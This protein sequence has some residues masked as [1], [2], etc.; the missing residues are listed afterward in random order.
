MSTRRRAALPPAPPPPQYIPPTLQTERPHPEV[1]RRVR[2]S[3]AT[4]QLSGKA[5]D[6]KPLPFAFGTVETHGSIRYAFRNGKDL[7][8]VRALALGK[9]SATAGGA[10]S[11]G[12]IDSL[13]SVKSETGFSPSM[14][15]FYESWFYTGSLVQTVN[16]QLAAI[17]ASWNETLIVTNPLTG[18]QRGI[19]YIVERYLN[20]V[21]YWQRYHGGLPKWLYRL[22]GSKLYDS[23]TGLTAYTENLFLQWRY[24]ATDPDGRNLPLASIDTTSFNAAATIGDQV[25]GTGKRYEAHVLMESGTV[26]DWLKMF[27]LLGDA[28]WYEK[29][30]GRWAVLIDS[31][32]APVATFTD[33]HYT[34]SRQVELGPPSD[35]DAVVNK[36]TIEYT[37]TT[38]AAWRTEPVTL[39]MPGVAAGTEPE[40]AA[41]YKMPELHH[42]AQA[43]TKLR[44]LLYGAQDDQRLSLNWRPN[45]GERVLG[46]VITQ[47]IPER[48]ISGDFRIF[49]RE[50]LPDGTIN[51]E[52]QQVSPRKYSDSTSATP[53]KF[54]S[55]PPPLSIPAPPMPAAHTLVDAW[56]PDGSDTT[57]RW[58]PPANYNESYISHYEVLKGRSDTGWKLWATVQRDARPTATNPLIVTGLTDKNWD[59]LTLG[60]TRSISFDIVAVTIDGQRS[61]TS[62][63]LGYSAGVHVAQSVS[64][65]GAA[66]RAA[67]Y[68]TQM[69]TLLSVVNGGNNNLAWQS[70][71]PAFFASGL[72]VGD[73]ALITGLVAPQVGGAI[74]RIFNPATLAATLQ[75]VHESASSTAANRLYTMGRGNVDVPPG[76][77]ALLEYSTSIARWLLVGVFGQP[78][79]GQFSALEVGGAST[80]T[81]IER[82]SSG[83]LQLGSPP[84][85]QGNDGA[86]IVKNLGTYELAIILN[87]HPS[88]NAS[89][90]AVR[91]QPG[92]AP[93][94]E[95]GTTGVTTFAN[96]ILRTGNEVGDC[97]TLGHASAANEYF[98]SWVALKNKRSSV[99]TISLSGGDY[100]VNQNAI[101]VDTVKTGG[102]RFGVRSNAAGETSAH[103]VYTAS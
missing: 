50:L 78:T 102:F 88:V 80:V 90:F 91:S 38:T 22:K 19:C 42:R 97:A 79:K 44:L 45:T 61:A 76:C 46:E 55:S 9:R 59:T 6:D 57:L 75:F 58:D 39:A 94:L 89:T 25:L 17:D 4:V 73:T 11:A 56:P 49:S 64:A 28:Y 62:L 96:D 12:E 27:R 7:W 100:A 71:A 35:A 36:V 60:G 26:D 1:T 18:E 63:A 31:L 74:L 34:S 40:V 95:I 8:L 14:T 66:N 29:D 32:Q 53:P 24:W 82:I 10:E 81:G 23:R 20:Y 72:G 54:T 83:T 3:T 69:D 52:L 99:P 13:L 16:A 77:Y 15:F 67:D 84:S 87:N 41:T 98:G 33:L 93:W 86:Q 85:S 70:G 101:F 103:R 68:V 5:E 21:D 65:S 92:A 51:V 2:S 48:S 43:E 47:A 37:D 30:D